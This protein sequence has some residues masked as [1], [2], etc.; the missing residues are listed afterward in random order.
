MKQIYA[1]DD[2]DDDDND[3]NDEDDNILVVDKVTL[4]PLYSGRIGLGVGLCG[5]RKNRKNQIKT[6][7]ARKRIKNK[8][9]PQGK[10]RSGVEPRW[11]G[12]GGG[13]GEREASA[14]TYIKPYL[15]N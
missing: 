2:D 1:D 15:N 11:Q 5:G 4:S 3:Y 7:G 10:S 9:N 13:W 8:L 6:L 14:L 12:G